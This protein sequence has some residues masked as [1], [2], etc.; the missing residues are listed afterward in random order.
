MEANKIMLDILIPSINTQ[1]FENF[2]LEN[3]SVQSISE[4]QLDFVTI[5]SIE[6]NSDSEQVIF[7]KAKE[8]TF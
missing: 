2:L 6:V 7:D 5:F 3:N 4:R 8:L 1:K